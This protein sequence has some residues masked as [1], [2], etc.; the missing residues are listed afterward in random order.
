MLPHHDDLLD[1]TSTLFFTGTG[2]LVD[3]YSSRTT[4][5]I[6]A[7]VRIALDAATTAR[8][9]VVLN[10]DLQQATVQG[11][12]QV[13]A[14]P[15][16]LFNISTGGTTFP[17]GAA[18]PFGAIVF[19]A[20]NP[21]VPLTSSAVGVALTVIGPTS[22]TVYGPTPLAFNQATGQ[23]TATLHTTGLLLGHY[24]A[25]FTFSRPDG[26]VVGIRSASF[27]LVGSLSL[28]LGPN[29]PVFGRGESVGLTG[30]V[31]D[32]SGAPIAGLAVALTIG[33]GDDTQQFSVFSNAQGNYGFVFTPPPTEAGTYV[34]TAR[35][36]SGGVGWQD[37]H[38]SFHE[39]GS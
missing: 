35:A 25:T 14:A 1:P 12:F 6:V 10:P 39:N 31:E 37:A 23:F 5:Q 15:N 28:T 7:N 16:F 11:G 32:P 19:D 30:R 27:D 17:Q 33:L 18:V 26:I 9:V 29:K 21:T 3:S 38:G 20:G 8:D 13:L 2:V 4:T 22:A 36:L 34:A 24:E